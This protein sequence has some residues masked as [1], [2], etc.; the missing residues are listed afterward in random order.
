[1]TI[2]TR[3]GMVLAA[4]LYV[5]AADVQAKA[6]AKD[7]GDSSRKQVVVTK[8]IV[9]RTSDTVTLKGMHFGSATP[10][11]YC[12]TSRM[13]VLSASDD[14]IVVAF[15]ASTVADGTYLF[16]VIR[17]EAP[18]DRA[19][20]YVT[21]TQGGSIKE[22]PMGP[23]GPQGPAGPAGPA[24][25]QGEM[26][27]MGPQGPAGPAGPAGPQGLQG[28]AG[29]QGLPGAPGAP[30]PEGPA[31]ADGVSGYERLIADSGLFTVDP[32]QSVTIEAPCPE[33]K[34]VVSGG[35]ELVEGPAQRLAVVMSGPFEDATAGWRV[36]VR[37]GSTA[38]LNYANV[39]AH[40]I[41]AAIR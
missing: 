21:A 19:P 1:M 16:T 30:G 6:K 5:G 13:T 33:G 35:H 9:D 37:N 20:F 11:V 14:E 41:C 40:V 3:T 32:S 31:G 34:V 26:G 10:F 7:D 36:T 18:Y 27:P 39:R 2:S 22:G 15:P 23:M 4:L 25:A 28:P 12:E 17:G 24:G 38:Q 8:A 29:P